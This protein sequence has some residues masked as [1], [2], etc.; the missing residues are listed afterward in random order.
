[1]AEDIKMFEGG[2]DATRD[3]LNEIVK[4]LNLLRKRVADMED[5]DVQTFVVHDDNNENLMRVE[6]RINIIEI[7]GAID[8]DCVDPDPDPTTTDELEGP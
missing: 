4:E 7:I 8:C 2:V 5:F 3:H 1:M 6:G